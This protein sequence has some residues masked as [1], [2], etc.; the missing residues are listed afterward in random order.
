VLAAVRVFTRK[1]NTTKQGRNIIKPNS[2]LVTTEL[3]KAIEI[4]HDSKMYYL[5]P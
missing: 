4:Y 3:V 2:V 5:G 1:E